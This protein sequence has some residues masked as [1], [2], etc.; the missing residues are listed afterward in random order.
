MKK[1]TDISYK[2]ESN[3]IQTNEKEKEKNEQFSKNNKINQNSIINKIHSIQASINNTNN[4]NNSKYVHRKNNF[5]RNG[6]DYKIQENKKTKSKNK[7]KMRSKSKL[8]NISKNKLINESQNITQNKNNSLYNKINHIYDYTNAITDKSNFN[9]VTNN[10][11]FTNNTTTS[12]INT[13]NNIII[14]INNYNKITPT[15]LE[16]SSKTI[17]IHKSKDNNGND[18][19]NNNNKKKKENKK[20]KYTTNDNNKNVAKK[21]IHKY[22]KDNEKKVYNYYINAHNLSVDNGQNNVYNNNIFLT[23]LMNNKSDKNDK[24]N[25][26]NDNNDN[27]SINTYN[28][29]NESNNNISS[30]NNTTNREYSNR[31]LIKKNNNYQDNIMLKKKQLGMYSPLSILK[32]NFEIPAKTENNKLN[33]NKQNYDT[34][35][36]FNI[37]DNNNKCDEISNINNIENS[38][39]NN[40]DKNLQNNINNFQNINKNEENDD[41]NKN[42]YNFNYYNINKKNKNNNY[43]NEIKQNENSKNITNNNT[44]KNLGNVNMNKNQVKN[45]LSKIKQIKNTKQIYNNKKAF[46]FIKIHRKKEK[47]PYYSINNSYFLKSRPSYSRLTDRN[48]NNNQFFYYSRSNSKNV[49]SNRNKNLNLKFFNFSHQKT[50]RSNKKLIDRSFMS[51]T[52]KMDKKK[53]TNELLLSY[54][55]KRNKMYIFKNINNTKSNNIKAEKTYNENE[56]KKKSLYDINDDCL[57]LNSSMNSN[58]NINNY[59]NKNNKN[60]NN[61]DNN[62]MK[63][64]LNKNNI[65]NIVSISTNINLSSNNNKIIDTYESANIANINKHCDSLLSKINQKMKEKEKE[66]EKE[67][68]KK[69]ENEFREYNGYIEYEDNYIKN[70]EENKNKIIYKKIIS[71]ASLSRRG[72]NRPDEVM[73]INQDTLFK[74]K[75]GDIN[76]SYY[77]V[78]DGHG[79]SGHFVSD[80]IKSNIAFIVYKH[81]KSLL[82]QNQNNN[83]SNLNDVD[84]TNIDFSKLF[85]DCFLLMDSKLSENKSIDIEL[86]GTTCISL[87]FCD[88]RI[89]SAN[90]GDSRAIKGQYNLN[91]NEWNYILLSRDH[92]P[93][94]KDEAD[95]IKKNNGIIHPYIDDDGNYAGPERVWKD[96]ELPGLAMSRSFGDEIASSVGVFSE[97]EV[98]IFPFYE[99]DK[100]IVIASDGLWEYV[101]NEEVIEIVS[102]YFE[103]KDCDGAVSKLYEISHER[104][105]QYDDYIDDISIIVVFLD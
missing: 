32:R 65:N 52:D 45:I 40:N 6:N 16:Q 21:I 61:I 60:S 99:E 66:K 13:N 36:S 46:A 104:W 9:N 48:V 49:L 96:D 31:T 2:T 102:E 18:N 97:P 100:F 72:L 84:D 3:N 51:E 89:I 53:S 34:V 69:K 88:N 58:T 63:N 29:I 10:S 22:K 62:N 23:H 78:C 95:R 59:C 85:K 11:F 8:K 73:K 38:E 92:K 74:V 1:Y 76:Y 64:I 12:G 94:E 24:N 70:N 90:V 68:S 28:T 79:P 17:P 27:V 15:N 33:C 25:I 41:K 55:K 71:N 98:K 5:R 93:S 37:T 39:N 87:L 57:T 91:T 47:I 43:N 54:Q 30:S 81:L 7:N 75:F 19:G 50:S 44:N 80:F 83:S 105:V 35:N 77:G 86:S 14:T 26:N 4:N 67:N 82:L 20:I 103:K 56:S 101:T 42:K